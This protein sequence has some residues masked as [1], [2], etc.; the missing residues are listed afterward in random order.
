MRVQIKY[1][2]EDGEIRFCCSE[3]WGATEEEYKRKDCE[4]KQNQ[5]FD[6]QC[7]GGRC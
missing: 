2:S 1:M 5:L 7:S 4:N 6:V 3:N